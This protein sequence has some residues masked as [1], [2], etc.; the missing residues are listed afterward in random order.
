MIFHSVTRLAHII[1]VII[2]S[3][4][5]VYLTTTLL[6]SS[7]VYVQ[8]Y[9]T[10]LLCLMYRVLAYFLSTRVVHTSGQHAKFH[11]FF[12]RNIF[13]SRRAFVFIFLI[14]NTVDRRTYIYTLNTYSTYICYRCCGMWIVISFDVHAAC[15]AVWPNA[16]EKCSSPMCCGFIPFDIFILCRY[17]WSTHTWISGRELNKPINLE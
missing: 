3:H 6:I 11:L 2:S 9:I 13:W 16:K 12:R 1:A 4:F 8:T 7:Y 14:S 15:H 10:H 5:H 17:W